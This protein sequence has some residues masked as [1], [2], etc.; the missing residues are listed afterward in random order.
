MAYV[1]NVL[2]SGC[3]YT[4]IQNT[5]GRELVASFLPPHGRTLAEDEIIHIAGDIRNAFPTGRG[6]G[7]RKLNAFLQAVE[8]GLL[9]ITSTPAPFFIDETTG[10]G[11]VAALKNGSLEFDFSCYDHSSVSE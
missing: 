2:H 4:T 6:A 11:K 9:T 3:F 1:S 10:L 5:S 7:S 8:D